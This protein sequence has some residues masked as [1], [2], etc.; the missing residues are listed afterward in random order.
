MSDGCRA[1][2]ITRHRVR[3]QVRVHLLFWAHT[4]R[5]RLLAHFSAIA[6][7]TDRKQPRGAIRGALRHSHNHDRT[8]STLLSP[9]YVTASAMLPC[10]EKS[11]SEIHHV[12][13]VCGVGSSLAGR[14]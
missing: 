14:M 3:C 10:D 11:S 5:Q 1:G 6:A 4:N 9:S 8:L 7:V 13:V 12:A 2:S